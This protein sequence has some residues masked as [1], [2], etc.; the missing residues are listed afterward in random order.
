[1]TLSPI[2]PPPE[3]MNAVAYRQA[4]AGKLM[5]ICRKEG[6]ELV[7]ADFFQFDSVGTHPTG[8]LVTGIFHDDRR[9]HMMAANVR[10]ANEAEISW[11]N[12]SLRREPA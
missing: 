7:A 12:S 1:M 9:S 6:Q 2:A 8:L 10:Q 3:E 4:H 11:R 5:V